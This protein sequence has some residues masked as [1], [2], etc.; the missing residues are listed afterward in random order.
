MNRQFPKEDIYIA[1][2]RKGFSYVAQ[3]GLKLPAS[4]DPP[5]LASQVV[6]LQAPSLTLSPDSGAVVRSRITATSTSRVQKWGL[7]MLARMILIFD[8]MISPPRP[9]KVLE[10]QAIFFQKYTPS[11]A[12]WLM[13]VI[14]ALWEAKVHGLR[15]GVRDQPGQYGETPSLLKIQKLAGRSGTQL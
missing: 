12:R 2:K 11:Q 7:T 15:S 13:P 4:S 8:F 9:L 5:T 6:G 3:A 14:P 10:L 1:N